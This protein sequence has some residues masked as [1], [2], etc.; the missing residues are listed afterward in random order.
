MIARVNE[1][2]ERGETFCL[3]TVVVS[4]KA[5]IPVGLKAIVLSDGSLEGALGSSRLG[6]KR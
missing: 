4:S 5:D 1:L 6:H 2:L 3:A